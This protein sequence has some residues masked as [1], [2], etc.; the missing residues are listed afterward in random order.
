MSKRTIAGLVGAAAVAL[1]TVAAVVLLGGDPPVAGLD[2]PPV[3]APPPDPTTTPSP[4]RVVV[5]PPRVEPVPTAA[6]ATET[7]SGDALV[8]QVAAIVARGERA[9]DAAQEGLAAG[10]LA[11]V[12]ADL[13]A[14]GESA[15]DDARRLVDPS[16]ASGVQEVGARVLAQLGT[17]GALETLADLARRGAA[18]ASARLQALRR[19]R[20]SEFPFARGALIDV[21]RDRSTDAEVRAYALDLMRDLPGAES[22]LDGVARDADDE[23][24]VRAVALDALL[25]LEPARGREALAAVGGEEALKPLL[26]AL[27]DR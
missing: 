12:L 24:R 15:T 27:R 10:D 1:I 14:R 4:P 25:T 13:A 19:L 3:V 23:A 2:V 9:R 20:A 17:T 5:E 7:A 21:A 6:P 22:I 18:P 16:C 26:E 11:R 8:A